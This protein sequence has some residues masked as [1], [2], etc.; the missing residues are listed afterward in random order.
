MEDI[1]FKSDDLVVMSSIYYFIT[2]NIYNPMII[3]GLYD[4][5][6][7]ENLKDDY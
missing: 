3:H 2:E 1:V 7:L 6:W 4:E 5:I